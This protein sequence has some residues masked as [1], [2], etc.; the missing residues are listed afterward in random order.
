MWTVHV[1]TF[2]SRSHRA[3]MGCP[4]ISDVKGFSTTTC[5]P[6]RRCCK[7]TSSISF[8]NSLSL[9][10]RLLRS[11]LVK[12]SLE[13]A[14]QW[15][16]GGANHTTAGRCALISSIVHSFELL[17]HVDHLRSGYPEVAKPPCHVEQ[18][19]KRFL[20][21]LRRAPSSAPFHGSAQVL[22]PSTSPG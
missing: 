3:S 5:P 7:I 11:C 9:S 21:L 10:R 19:P 20:L 18:M 4:Q 12:F 2:S 1:H 8:R 6:R 13:K 17:G 15:V 14:H 22:S 16:H